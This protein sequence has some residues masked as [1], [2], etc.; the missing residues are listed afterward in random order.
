[1][2][3]RSIPLAAAIALI[4]TA[5]AAQPLLQ[6]GQTIHGQLD[7][8]DPRLSTGELC[9]EY[10][11][12]GCVGQ[13]V[14]IRMSSNDVDTYLIYIAPSGWQRDNDDFR[15][16]DSGLDITLPST[17]IHR[18]LATTYQPGEWGGYTL[19]LTGDGP[20]WP[21]ESPYPTTPGW[22]NAPISSSP[23]SGQTL[24]GRLDPADRRLDT[25]EFYEEFTVEVWP[26]Q[27]LSI[28]LDSDDFDP[29]LI[30][31]DPSGRQI[32]DDDSGNGLNS[33][34]DL[35]ISSGGTLRILATSFSE[36]EMGAYALSVL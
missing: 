34:L 12:H 20:P 4:A 31:I 27:R 11:F 17:G 32:D 8:C 7:G 5:A 16:T 10:L 19:S 29:Y 6:F 25:G 36:G 21:G 2:L 23:P 28:Q 13:R 22:G 35:T 14:S 9:E 15:G 30:V 26:G 24:W 33:A 1:M 18:I 3:W